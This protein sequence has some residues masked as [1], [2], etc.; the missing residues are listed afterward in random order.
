MTESCDVIA[1]G[2]AIVDVLAPVDDS[3][4]TAN[5]VAKG[6]MTLVDE[7]RA[8]QLYAALPGERREIAGGSA[9]NTMAGLASLGGRGHFIGKVRDDALGR[10]FAAGLKEIGIGFTSSP[11]VAGPATA[12]CM[13]AVAPDGQRS[14]N[15]F[16]GACRG[17]TADD[18]TEENI[19]AAK[20]LYIE[21]YLWDM[22]AAKAASRKAIA[23]A[24]RSGVKVAFTLSDPFCVGRF[25][26]EF[27]DL[28]AN[29]LDIV[30]ANQDEANALFATDDFAS[31]QRELVGWNGIAAVT[32][33][34]KGCVAIGDGIV[35]LV[36]ASPVEKVI[37]TTGAGDAFAAGFLYGLTRGKDLAAC[38]RLGALA[39]GEIISHFGARPEVPLRDLAAAAS[40]T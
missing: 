34:E 9:A 18:I 19:A 6:V 28:F 40:L 16:L 35:A 31:A 14:M 21:G 10:T 27:L 22:E 33:S 12:S 24:K 37:D 26:Q 20:I 23:I 13:I 3:F 36:P 29:D 8:K 39:A 38:G 15:T 5:D 30:F 25:R 17:L 11:A 7:D 1:M 2:N 4:L 32:R